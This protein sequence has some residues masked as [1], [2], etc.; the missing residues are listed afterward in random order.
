MSVEVDFPRGGVIAP[1]NSA[2]SSVRPA[3]NATTTNA[4]LSATKKHNYKRQRNNKNKNKSTTAKKEYVPVYESKNKYISMPAPTQVPDFSDLVVKKDNV[5]STTIKDGI[6]MLGAVSSVQPDHVIVQ[7]PSGM[8]GIIRSQ[9]DQIQGLQLG[10]LLAVSV[11]GAA[12]KGLVSVTLSPALINKNLSLTGLKRGMFIAG[13]ILSVEDRGY[14]VDVGIPHVTALLVKTARTMVKS[15]PFL[16]IIQAIEPGSKVVQLS[17]LPEDMEKSS[18]GAWKDLLFSSVLPGTL[19]KCIVKEVFSN[20]VSVKFMDSVIGFV[21]ASDLPHPPSHF[22]PGFKIQGRVTYIDDGTRR[23]GLTVAQSLVKCVPPVLPPGLIG[24]VFKGSLISWADD[25]F[26]LVE[27]PCNPPIIGALLYSRVNKPKQEMEVGTRIE[28]TVIETDYLRGRPIVTLSTVALSS[29]LASVHNSS[30]SLLSPGCIVSGTIVNILAQAIQVKLDV[31][32]LA[33]CASLHLADVPVSKVESMFSLD[34]RVTCRILSIEGDSKIY[35]TNKKT[36]VNTPYRTIATYHT[37]APGAVSHGWVSKVSSLIGVT[38]CFYGGVF[39]LVPAS[40]IEGDPTKMYHEGQVVLC[41]VVKCQKTKEGQQ[42]YTLTLTLTLD[43]PPTTTISTDST[44]SL[45]SSTSIGSFVDGVVSIC[46]NTGLTV[47]LENG[48][49]AFL[50]VSHMSDHPTHCH[51]LLGRY[52]IGARIG[53][54]VVLNKDRATQRLFLTKKPSLLQAASHGQKDEEDSDDDDDE[55]E[56]E[57]KAAVVKFFPSNPNEIQPKTMLFGHVRQISAKDCVIGFGGT[58]KATVT[59]KSIDGGKEGMVPSDIL[60]LG[61]TVRAYVDRI[62]NKNPVLTLLS[63][64][65]ATD[66]L[67]LLAVHFADVEV[68]RKGMEIQKKYQKG[69]TVQATI[70][71]IRSGL[72]VSIA[73]EDALGFVSIPHLG[74]PLESYKKGDQIA[75]MVLDFDDEEALFDLSLLPDLINK[76]INKKYKPQTEQYVEARIEL[77]KPTHLFISISTGKSLVFGYAPVSD[78]NTLTTHKTLAYTV[79]HK[80]QV[81][82]SSPVDGRWIFALQD[83]I[84]AAEEAAKRCLDLA[85]SSVQPEEEEEQGDEETQEEEDEEEVKRPMKKRKTEEVKVDYYVDDKHALDS[86]ALEATMDSEVEDDSDVDVSDDSDAYESDVNEHLHDDRKRKRSS[87]NTPSVP[88]SDKNN[89]QEK[90]LKYH[91]TAVR[92]E[93]RKTNKSNKTKPKSRR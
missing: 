74:L 15:Q 22:P 52:P 92:R 7:L 8:R 10:D 50:P 56:D 33:R 19:A 90:A 84:L 55:G 9:N 38:V 53:K 88:S 39:G 46:D 37:A 6:M 29:S 27:L 85:S 36:M 73:G 59:A 17:T 30:T 42:P 32:G 49:T 12:A 68:L 71:Q 75:A 2:D 44:L 62:S 93:N 64:Y 1:I 5:F 40:D 45:L 81:R 80:I 26:A 13:R 86:S 47:Q 48:L 79:G 61:Q 58:C 82:A 83:R 66:G 91:K 16:A 51:S 23:V 3:K 18:V 63:S 69:Q 24:T 28:C 14:T 77:I 31:G 76:P 25:E 54:S 78:Y 70:Q 21:P 67:D 89:K 87:N 20:G 43:Y 65:C 34:E 4:T 57:Q 41:K 72:V 35:L 11:K 60:E